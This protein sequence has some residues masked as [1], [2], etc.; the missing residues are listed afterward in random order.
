MV[1]TLFKPSKEGPSSNAELFK[2]SGQ[3]I[4][5]A[6]ASQGKSPLTLCL[7]S[8]PQYQAYLEQK[9]LVQPQPHIVSLKPGK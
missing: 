9:N 4:S 7:M 2:N 6:R 1:A 3:E 8:G 5:D